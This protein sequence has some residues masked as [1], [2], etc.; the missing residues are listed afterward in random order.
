MNHNSFRKS[1][2]SLIGS[3]LLAKVISISLTPILTR[4]Y[5]PEDFGIYTAAMS[6]MTVCGG[7]ISLRLCDAIPIAKSE[8]QA[9]RMTELSILIGI[10]MAPGAYFLVAPFYSSSEISFKYSEILIIIFGAILISVYETLTF[11][12]VRKSEFKVISITQLQQSVIGGGIKVLGGLLGT[13]SFGLIFGSG[14]QQGFGI[15]YMLKRYDLFIGGLGKFFNKGMLINY[16]LLRKYNEYPRF[17]L[18]SR[19]VLA[20][21]QALPIIY[22]T[23]E[24]GS[25][26]VGFLGLAMSMISIPATMVIGN[27]RKVYYGEI[28]KISLS[29]SHKIMSL[30]SSIILKMLGMAVVFSSLLFFFAEQLFSIVFGQNWMEAGTYSKVLSLQVAANFFTGPIIDAFNVF[31]KV[32]YYFYF[33]LFK[34][35]LTL[36]MLTFSFLFSLSEIETLLYLSISVALYYVS[37]TICIL[38]MIKRLN[39]DI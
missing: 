26:S 18:P 37:Q 10:I 20:I 28:S 27:V 31:G 25:E 13:G 8:S 3:S 23:K 32:K 21:S 35:A 11:Y 17:R 16:S 38:L 4:L 15:I 34:L 29:E 39:N 22:F 36:S 5:E 30:T 12:S 24:Y 2:A 19:T 1:I 14:F 6:I 9:K 7:L 33:N